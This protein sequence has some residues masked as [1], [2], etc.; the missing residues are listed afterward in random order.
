MPRVNVHGKT[1]VRFK[2]GYT[3]SK[4]DSMLRN[5]VTELFINGHVEV[6]A[7]TATEVRSLADKMITFAK[8]GD[9]AARREAA[10]VVRDRFA[11]KEEKTTALQKLFGEIAEKYKDRQGGY[12]RI[13]KVDN[14]RG[15][16]SPMAIVE[17]V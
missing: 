10:K 13:I 5:V 6:T 14:R 7:K 16:N 4:N 11:D 9:L 15:D 3:T 1:G 2:T 8:K 12:T 17:L